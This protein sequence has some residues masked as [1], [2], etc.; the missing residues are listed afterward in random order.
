MILMHKKPTWRADSHRIV[1]FA[2]HYNYSSNSLDSEWLFPSHPYTSIFLSVCGNLYFFHFTPCLLCLGTYHLGSS[3]S[4]HP[5]ICLKK[6]CWQFRW[7]W[8]KQKGNS[9]PSFIFFLILPFAIG[10]LIQLMTPSPILSYPPLF[11]WP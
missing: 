3:F 2:H 9:K 1:F 8:G 11:S 10:S 6:M 7:W 5:N 4:P